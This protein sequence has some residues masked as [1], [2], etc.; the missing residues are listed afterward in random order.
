MAARDGTSRQG[1]I[2]RTLDKPVE[3][4][5]DEIIPGAA[6]AMEDCGGGI[7][8]EVGKQQPPQLR[9]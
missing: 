8:D 3:W 7:E 1:P 5:V 2:S 6:E 9:G 4:L